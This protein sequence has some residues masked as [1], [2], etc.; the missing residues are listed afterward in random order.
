MTRIGAAIK[1]WRSP[2]SE[3]FNDNR[4]F[5][6]TPDAGGKWKGM[7]KALFDV[8]KTSLSELLGK[9]PGKL[10]C[11]CLDSKARQN[12]HCAI[13]EHLHQSRVR[14]AFKVPQHA[15]T[16]LRPVIKREESFLDT[17]SGDPRKACGHSEECI[18]TSRAKRGLPLR[19]R[20]LVSAITP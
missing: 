13:G 5:N 16:V 8:D 1:A 19:A 12:H 9:W 4:C 14:D 2:V 17:A 6:S 18:I 20:P 3:A 11:T 10:Q 7:V 15:A